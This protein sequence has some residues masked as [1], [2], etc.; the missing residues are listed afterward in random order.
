MVKRH[1]GLGR[2]LIAPRSYGMVLLLIAV[3]YGLSVSLASPTAGS[4]ILVVQVATVWFVLRTSKARPVVRKAANVLLV[5]AV[6]IAVGALIFGD[7]R[8]TSTFVL[9]A[10]TMLY[11]VAPASIMRDLIGRPKV[12]AETFLGAISAYLLIGLCFALAYRTLGVLQSAP[13]FGVGGEGTT[14]QTLF[15]SFTTLTTTGYGNLVPAGNPGQTLAVLEM[16]IGQIFLASAIAKVITSWT[17]IR[18]ANGDTGGVT[19]S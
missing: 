10:S 1:G 14:A 12:D 2:R 17:P 5:I 3:C 13:F 16:V 6:G 8:E 15:F 4:L 19:P 9:A 7:A 18:H 11:L